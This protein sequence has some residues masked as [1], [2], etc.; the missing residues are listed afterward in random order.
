MSIITLVGC[1]LALVITALAD[2]GQDLFKEV[3]KGNITSVEQLLSAGAEP[4]TRK[5]NHWGNF[6]A[7]HEAA[8][9]NYVNV[10]R[11]LI[12]AGA[13]IDIKDKYERTPLHVASFRGATAVVTVLAAAGA[14]KNESDIA[15]VLLRAGAN[16]R[17][18]NNNGTTPLGIAQEMGHVVLANIIDDFTISVPTSTIIMIVGITVEQHWSSLLAA[19]C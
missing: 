10:T 5:R 12:K 3:Q 4:N 1:V 11:A 19:I 18:L 9:Y 14:R 16:T 6:S 2:T 7:L 8:W 17:K 13:E 15:Q